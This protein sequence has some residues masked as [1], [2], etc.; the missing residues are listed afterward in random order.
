M[1]KMHY[2]NYSDY[3]LLQK[4]FVDQFH[5]LSVRQSVDISSDV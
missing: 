1:C 4:P 2:A 5:F 3:Q